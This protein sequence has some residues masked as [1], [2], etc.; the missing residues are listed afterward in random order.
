MI[1][2]LECYAQHDR[3]NSACVNISCD[4]SSKVDK[5]S[6]SSA[7]LSKLCHLVLHNMSNLHPGIQFSN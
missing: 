3:I 2:Q 1:F 7:A 4:D 5:N 6:I